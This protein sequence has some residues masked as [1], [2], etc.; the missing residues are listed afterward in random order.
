MKNEFGKW[1]LTKDQMPPKGQWILVA[2]N[3]WQKPWEIERYIG[4]RIN[5]YCGQKTNW[6]WEDYEYDAWTSGHG[7][8]GEDAP[9]AW[10]PLPEPFKG[11]KYGN[12]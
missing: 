1:I 12:N 8:I 4:K 2:K 3:N 9:I 7:D 6:E 11:D 10:M 5:Q